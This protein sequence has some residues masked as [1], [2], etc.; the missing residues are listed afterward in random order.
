MKNFKKIFAIFFCVATVVFGVLVTINNKDLFEGL[1]D[2]RSTDAFTRNVAIVALFYLFTDILL[3]LLPV[4]GVLAVLFDKM[5]PFKAMT[6]CALVVLIKF[7]FD[8]LLLVIVFAAA[9]IQ[10]DWKEFFFGKDSMAIIPLIVFACAFAF[11]LVSKANQFE[12]TLFRAVFTTIGSGLAIFGLVFY[13]VLGKGGNGLVAMGENTSIPS[14]LTIVGLCVGI[15]C[16]AGL[17]VYSY[18]PQTREFG[19]EQPKE[20][21]PVEEEKPEEPKAE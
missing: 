12:G 8:M 5:T 4:V 16:F 17:V 7:L 6:N 10:I 15:A 11:L 1:K 19:E 9:E 13:F 18:L 21:Q 3:I 14:W 20:E 2:L